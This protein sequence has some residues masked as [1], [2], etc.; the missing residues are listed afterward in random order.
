MK[1]NKNCQC[2][3]QLVS[4]ESQLLMVDISTASRD[5]SLGQ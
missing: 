1:W 3:L 2:H 5:W 4:V